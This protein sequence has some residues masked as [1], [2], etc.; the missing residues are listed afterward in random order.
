M[1]SAPSC[2]RSS[3]Y[4][5]QQSSYCV[6][7]PLSLT[8]STGRRLRR[9]ITVHSQQTPV[10]CKINKSSLQWQF[11]VFSLM[12]WH[13][14]DSAIVRRRRRRL[15]RPRRRLRLRRRR[16]S[17]C[18]WEAIPSPS[19]SSWPQSEASRPSPPSRRGRPRS[20]C[21]C[22]Q[23]QDLLKRDRKVSGEN[24]RAT[25]DCLNARAAQAK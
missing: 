7:F 15:R 22:V 14:H 16:R 6:N 9:W 21:S 24:N 20:P 5:S 11:T 13:V 1:R 8:P 18:C 3:F 17:R 19:S 25:P 4:P 12:H 2:T 10:L 23:L